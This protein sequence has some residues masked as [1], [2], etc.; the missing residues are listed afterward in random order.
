MRTNKKLIILI[1]LAAVG[2]AASFVVS[3]FIGGAPQ[4]ANAQPQAPQ[5][6]Q[7]TGLL[8]AQLAAGGLGEMRPREKELDELVKELRQRMDL[9]RQ[10]EIELQQEEKRMDMA[11]R[12]LR[13]QAQELETLRIQLVAPLARLKEAQAEM[14]RT[15]VLLGK[16]EQANLK[17]M[18]ARYEKMKSE[19]AAE[20]MTEM[21]RN[22][23]VDDPVKILFLMSERSAAKV[24]AAMTDRKLAARLLERMKRIEQEG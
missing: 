11:R 24:L 6:S 23:Q 17:K 7:R 3:M 18:A 9:C 20:I 21:C 1:V 10:K 8:L 14:R 2:F 19:A 5:P 15:R 4:P 13:R 12:Q 22:N 16:Q